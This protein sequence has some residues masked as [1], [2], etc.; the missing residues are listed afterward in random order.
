LVVYSGG[1][2]LRGPQSTGFLLGR[3]GLCRA[4]WLNGPPHQALGRALKIGKEEMVGALV[5]LE[6]GFDGRLAA[7]CAR[8]Q[9]RLDVIRAAVEAL[10]GV[11]VESIAPSAS[12]TAARMRISWDRRE[13][14]LDAETVRRHL[15][16]QRPR[17]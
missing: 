10:R 6:R 4:A 5:A 11:S 16:A 12:V 1:K 2:Y 14:P 8:W 3:E 17:V 15:L 9:A 7:E 13:I